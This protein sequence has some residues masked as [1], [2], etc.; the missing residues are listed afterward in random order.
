MKLRILLAPAIGLLLGNPAA[1]LPLLT[2]FINELHYDNLGTDLN[3]FIE[4]AGSPQSLL[5][6]RLVLY[7]GGN[8]TSYRD[9]P[10]NTA[11]PDQGNGFGAIALPVNG[12]QNGPADGIA[13]VDGLHLHSLAIDHLDPPGECRRQFCPCGIM[14]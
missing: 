8:G 7:N 6:F 13:L 14:L 12:L 1:A 10:L 4:I 5:G 11:I 2:P 3:E 9:I